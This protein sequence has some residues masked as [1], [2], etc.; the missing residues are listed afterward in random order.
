MK[1]RIFGESVRQNFIAIIRH[2]VGRMSQ[3]DDLVN[4]N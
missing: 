4:T 2:I 3:P 1:L